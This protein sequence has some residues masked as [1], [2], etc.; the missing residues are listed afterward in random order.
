MNGSVL[1]G[2]QGGAGVQGVNEGVRQELDLFREP[3]VRFHE[4]T[5]HFSEGR[6]DV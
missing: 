4:L 1:T 2:F 5:I 3:R 6:E